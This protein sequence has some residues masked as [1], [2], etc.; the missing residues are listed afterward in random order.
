LGAEFQIV[1][2]TD[3]K[4]CSTICVPEEYG[5]ISSL[6]MSEQIIFIGTSNGTLVR[7]DISGA[8]AVFLEP[9]N[10]SSGKLIQILPANDSIWLL[11][12][13]STLI[14]IENFDQFLSLAEVETIG[15]IRKYK[16]D[17]LVRQVC[18]LPHGIEDKISLSWNKR[19]SRGILAVGNSPMIQLSKDLKSY[20]DDILADELDALKIKTIQ[21]ANLMSSAVGSF[22]R[23]LFHSSRNASKESLHLNATTSEEAVSPSS[24]KS[25]RLCKS[26][27]TV[28]VG[29]EWSMDDAGRL[30]ENLNLSNCSRYALV[31]DSFHGRILL[32]DIFAGFFVRQWKGYRDG[33]AFFMGDQMQAVFVQPKQTVLELWDTLDNKRIERLD[34]TSFIEDNSRMK[35]KE[36][37]LLGND[38]VLVTVARERS[39]LLRTIFVRIKFF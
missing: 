34:L 15:A 4:T 38:L 18:P 19:Y 6:S 36:V 12:T 10:L 31:T 32:L 24:P 21:A 26:K 9:I 17:G 16:L 2:V 33:R 13:P 3:L 23:N 37:L 27:R 1:V 28:H 14:F 25:L 39:N 29:S 5:I 35:I 8:E 20:E 7:A 22:A 30:F 11:F